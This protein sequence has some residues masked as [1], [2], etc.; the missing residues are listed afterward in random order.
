[1]KITNIVT[2]GYFEMLNY[3]IVNCQEKDNIVND[4]DSNPDSDSKSS[5]IFFLIYLK[6]FIGFLY[7]NLIGFTN[8]I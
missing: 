7:Y 8:I 1:M 3:K 6:I 2:S 5:L 4:S